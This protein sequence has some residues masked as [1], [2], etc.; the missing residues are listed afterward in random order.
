MINDVICFKHR[1]Y[2]HSHPSPYFIQWLSDAG[3]MKVS[4]IVRVDFQIGAYKDTVKCD[5]VPMTVC[6]LLLGRPWQYDR[7]VHH[8]GK[9]NT[10]EFKWQSKDVVVRP[11]SPQAIVNESRQKTKVNLEHEH[12]RTQRQ[13]PALIV[14]DQT[15]SAVVHF[16]ACFATAAQLSSHFATMAEPPFLTSATSE[17]PSFSLP[18]HTSLPTP[19]IIPAV[20]QDVASS[21]PWHHTEQ[22]PAAAPSQASL[23]AMPALSACSAGG[24]DAFMLMATKDDLRE[25]GDTHSAMPL[26]LVYK[27]EILVSN[28]ITPLSIRVSTVLQEFRDVF[29]EEVPDGLPPLRGIEHQIDLIPGASL[30]N[31]APYRTNPDETK[32]IQKQV[33]ALLDKG[34]ICVSLSP[35]VVPVILVP[36]KDGT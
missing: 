19:T 18:R 15:S 35:C 28:D 8:N 14:H 12:E 30:P 17:I 20:A 23:P 32:E 26:V 16:T 22:T 21:L 24:A 25:F 1:L 33:Q 34:Y 4:H 2:L 27:G 36:K 5:V 31:R 3:E 11:M 10:Y 9:A 29:L 13:E 6:H 7:D